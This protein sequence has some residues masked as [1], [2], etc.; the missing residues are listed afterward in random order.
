MA[1]T[2]L[3]ITLF[4]IL[5]NLLTRSIMS[6]ELSQRS[7]EEEEDEAVLVRKER[8]NNAGFNSAVNI[9]STLLSNIV[10]LSPA[11]TSIS[12]SSTLLITTTFW[13]TVFNIL[14]YLT[15]FVWFTLL[16]FSYVF[17]VM[18]L[19]LFAIVSPASTDHIS[20][21]VFNGALFRSFEDENMPLFDKVTSVGY[22]LMDRSNELYNLVQTPQ[23][24]KYM[25][26][27]LAATLGDQEANGFVFK[28]LFRSIS[29]TLDQKGG[30]EGMTRSVN[31]G[32]LTGDCD[33][34]VMNCPELAPYFRRIADS[35]SSYL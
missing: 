30:T 1:A 2:L 7:F 14:Q 18:V 16:L 3:R 24:S 27:H 29:S 6:V 17:G 5:M 9:V 32:L 31:V 22:G 26:C 11:N 23:C 20:N 21:N 35:W 12:N 15:F 10:V 8:Q 13:N 28:D 33:E 4:F 34:P 19:F 25:M